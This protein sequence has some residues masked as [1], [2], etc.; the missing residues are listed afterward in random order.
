MGYDRVQLEFR[1]KVAILKFNHPEVRNAI[2]AQ[3]LRELGQAVQEV[4]Q[5]GG[6]ARC[7]LLTGEGEA[8]C[9]GANLPEQPCLALVTSS[10]RSSAFPVNT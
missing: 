8:F 1:D 3:M 6:E 10:A 5:A 9:A 2:G 4:R 7:L